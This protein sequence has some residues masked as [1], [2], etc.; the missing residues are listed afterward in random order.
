MSLPGSFVVNVRARIIDG[1]VHASRAPPLAMHRFLF[2]KR[3]ANSDGSKANRE[4]AG[5]VTNQ[6][7]DVPLRVLLLHVQS[8]ERNRSFWKIK[9]RRRASAIF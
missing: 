4:I 2:I 7:V 1:G 3:S 8:M 6:Q 9:F 5:T